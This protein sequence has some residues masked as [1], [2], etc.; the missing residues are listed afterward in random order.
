MLLFST[1]LDIHESLTKEKFIQLVIAW[2]QGSPHTENIISGLE[3][4]GESNVRYGDNRL[5]MAVDEY[6]NGNIVAIRYEKREADGAIWDTDYVMNF[7]SMKM[8]IRL[9]RSF[10][11]DAVVTNWKFATPHI[12]TLLIEKGYLS[13]DGVLAVGRTSHTLSK[14]ELPLLADIVNGKA[15]CRLPVVYVSKTVCN[16][17]PVDVHRMAGRLKGIAHVL[18]QSDASLNTEIRTLCS[19][20]NEYHGAIGIYHPNQMLGHRRY[21]YH[22]NG[23]TDDLLMEK[24]IRTIMQYSNAQVVDLLYT[25]QGVNN[26]LLGDRLQSQREERIAAEKKLTQERT[27]TEALLDSCEDDLQKLQER[28]N[29][30][31]QANESLLYENQGLRYKLESADEQPVLYMGDEREFYPG[32]VRELLL[33]V[34]K[35]ALTTVV[36]EKSRRFDIVQDIIRNNKFEGLSGEHAKE[37][38]RLLS[39]YAGMTKPVR[40]GLERLGFDIGDDG[41]HYKLVY[42]GDDRY[43]GPL[44]KTPS[45]VRSGKNNM[46]DLIKK[47]F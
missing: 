6:R 42:H 45:D 13:R 20:Q 28:V 19:D 33:E 15:Q 29:D 7:A 4:H 37:L 18:V 39:A 14:E 36:Q 10:T 22:G 32:E 3:W 12:I 17:D 8:A 25:W 27:E 31:T 47:V 16:H 1:I 40:Q 35:R 34:L 38:E 41:K 26:A 44:P 23:A 43:W 24:I 2:N 5:W 30:L 11:Q 21:L 9:E 46:R